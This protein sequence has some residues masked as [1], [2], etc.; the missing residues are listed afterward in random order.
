VSGNAA[1]Y[2]ASTMREALT[3]V[4][5][6]RVSVPPDQIRFEGGQMPL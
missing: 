4:A 5:A 2:A 1:R 6:E 3:A